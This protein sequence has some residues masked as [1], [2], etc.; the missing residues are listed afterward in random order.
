MMC[1]I[2]DLIIKIFQESSQILVLLVEEC[3]ISLAEDE[4]NAVLLFRDAE[5]FDDNV[6]AGWWGLVLVHVFIHLGQAHGDLECLLS[7]FNLTIVIT[8]KSRQIL[9][10]SIE[11]IWCKELSLS[12]G[13]VNILF[14][15]F[16]IILLSTS[17]NTTL[18][19]CFLLGCLFCLFLLFYLFKFSS[20]L[21]KFLLDIILITD[22]SI[23]PRMWFNLVDAESLP[24]ISLQHFFHKIFK[25]ITKWIFL[26]VYRPKFVNLTRGQQIVVWIIILC[27]SKSEVSS[28]NDEK[29]HCSGENINFFTLIVSLEQFRSHV[30]LSSDSWF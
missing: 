23:K 2:I 10:N 20:T 16:L 7:L 28:E 6:H 21:S 24:R 5:E 1:S 29:N 19:S 27:G 9:I 8:G 22:W 13:I 17:V 4:L 3:L 15:N 26:L 18:S 14:S 12:L 30:V 11:V 25:I